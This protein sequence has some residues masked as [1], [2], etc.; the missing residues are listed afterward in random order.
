[1]LNKCGYSLSRETFF[2]IIEKII[3][4]G[5]LRETYLNEHINYVT[6]DGEKCRK[7]LV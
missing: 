5:P 3:F 4:A 2:V 7:N 1:M 6:S